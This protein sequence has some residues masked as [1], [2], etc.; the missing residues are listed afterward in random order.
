M[1]LYKKWKNQKKWQKVVSAGIAVILAIV[2]LAV[3]V[4]WGVCQWGKSSLE[5]SCL[6][7]ESSGEE[8][9][10]PTASTLMYNGEYYVSREDVLTFL[11]LGIDNWEVVSPAKDGISGGQSDALFLVAVDLKEEKINVISIDRNAIVLL[12]VYDSSGTYQYQ[13][14]GQ[15]TL[16]HGY[17]DGM[18]ISC[19]R[20][21][22]TVS[23]LFSGIPIHGYFSVNMGAIGVMNETVGGVELVSMDSFELP[24]FYVQEGE[25]IRLGGIQAYHYLKY[26]DT[27][28]P[29]SAA[30][31]A[32][33]QK[34]YLNIFAEQ[35]LQQTR[36][37]IGF[38]I[39]FYESIKPFV[40]TDLELPEMIYLA[41]EVS[42]YDFEQF[43]I[44]S[45]PG[46]TVMGE[47]FEEF[48]IDETAFFGLVTELFYEK[49]EM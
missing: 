42:G 43:Q 32:E 34:Q 16:Q 4:F 12:D 14:Y 11:V 20:T 10:A 7:D 6:R 21:V 24:H 18:E 22:N 2:I 27:S 45:L 49:L 44:S 41:S 5:A 3:G 17:G 23:R 30:K 29:N 31:R 13:G 38:P 28:V 15:I 37:D 35:A 1:K 48:Y 9:A 39:E 36:D 33:R 26:R 46:E 19:E 47:Q 25:T 40:V 8:Q